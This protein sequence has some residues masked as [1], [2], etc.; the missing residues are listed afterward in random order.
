MKAKTTDKIMLKAGAFLLSFCM[1]LGMFTWVSALQV[2][3]VEP[4]DRSNGQ[5]LAE[6]LLGEALDPYAALAYV[7]GK[8]VMG[9]DAL[10]NPIPVTTSEGTYRNPTAYVYF[11]EVY[12]S[13]LDTNVPIMLRI[14]DAD[15]DNAGTRIML[16]PFSP[17]TE[18]MMTSGITVFLLPKT[19]TI[20]AFPII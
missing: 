17:N 19:C 16:L 3:A 5:T 6:E 13:D 1:L 14:L 12:V 10:S 4:D 8:I 9:T 18:S 7:N 20:S 2:S 11:G 15:A